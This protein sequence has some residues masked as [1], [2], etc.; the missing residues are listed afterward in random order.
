MERNCFERV[1]LVSSNHCSHPKDVKCNIYIFGLVYNT[2][3]T[4]YLSSRAHVYR[5]HL[6]ARTHK[7]IF[8][9]A[10]LTRDDCTCG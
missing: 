2:R 7:R 5:K 6:T 1:R 8:S 4:G 10:H 3:Q 9:R